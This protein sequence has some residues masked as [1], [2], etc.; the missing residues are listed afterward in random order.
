MKVL[1]VYRHVIGQIYQN[2]AKLFRVQ[3]SHHVR[4]HDLG[5]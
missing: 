5:Q 2:G 1:W 3:I 4:C